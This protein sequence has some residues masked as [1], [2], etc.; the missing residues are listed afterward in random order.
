VTRTFDLTISGTTKLVDENTTSTATFKVTYDNMRLTFSHPPDYRFLVTGGGGTAGRMR[1]TATVRS[2]RCD[3]PE[4]VRYS[5]RMQLT[6]IGNT[7]SPPIRRGEF[8]GKTGFLLYL[9]SRLESSGTPFFKKC[10]WYGSESPQVLR[11]SDRLVA[12]FSPTEQTF[13]WDIAMKQSMERLSYPLA[14]LYRGKGLTVSLAADQ[15]VND[16][17]FTGRVQIRFT[18]AAR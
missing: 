12:I 13:R 6:I 9:A 16:R 18:R 1:A 2:T 11:R 10:R 7:W 15:A 14:D 5:G 4:T 8:P 3:A 17:R